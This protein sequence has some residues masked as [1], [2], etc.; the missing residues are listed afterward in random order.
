MIDRLVQIVHSL[1]KKKEFKRITELVKRHAERM[2]KK[3]EDENEKELWDDNCYIC[4]NPPPPMLLCC[5]GCCHAFHLDCIKL[6]NAPPGCVCLLLFKVCLRVFQE[7]GFVLIARQKDKQRKK[8][9][10]KKRK[11]RRKRRRKKWK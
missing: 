6:L 11:E 2:E 5:D 9:R 4:K 8:P 10:K 3:E 1:K 7:I